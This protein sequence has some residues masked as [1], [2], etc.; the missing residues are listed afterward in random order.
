MSTVCSE[1]PDRRTCCG[2]LDIAKGL[3]SRSK[4]R[5]AVWIY[6][7]LRL[8]AST[9]VNS[10]DAFSTIATVKGQNMPKYQADQSNTSLPRRFANLSKTH[11]WWHWSR[12]VCWLTTQTTATYCTEFK[13]QKLQWVRPKNT[14]EEAEPSNHQQ[15]KSHCMLTTSTQ[16]SK[17]IPCETPTKSEDPKLQREKLSKSKRLSW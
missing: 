12:T 17:N 7:Q 3:Y 2:D 15:W 11:I 10:A 4:S 6:I 5:L 14:T 1:V 13:K 9:C 8:K 16:S